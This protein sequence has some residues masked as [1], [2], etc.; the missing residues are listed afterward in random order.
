MQANTD[1][2]RASILQTTG[3][4]WKHSEWVNTIYLQGS[5]RGVP[6]QIYQMNNS[7]QEDANVM[8]VNKY[9][10]KTSKN[11]IYEAANQ[12]WAEQIVFD[13]AQNRVQTDSKVFNSN[14]TASGSKYFK[15]KW[16]GKFGIGQSCC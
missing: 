15:N 4:K 9:I 1:Y 8:M 12:I 16:Y 3:Y 11:W 13:N 5:E 2:K 6:P 7:R 14:T 10:L